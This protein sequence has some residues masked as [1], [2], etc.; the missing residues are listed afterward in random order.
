MTLFARRLRARPLLAAAGRAGRVGMRAAQLIAPLAIGEAEAEWVARAER[1]TVRQ[2]EDALKLAKPGYEP[3]PAD[4]EPAYRLTARVTEEQRKDVDEGLALAARLLPGSTREEQLEAFAQEWLGS[5][6]GD[7]SQDDK[8][9]IS[10][11][12]ERIGPRPEDPRAKLEAEPGHDALVVPIPE[13]AP[14]DVTF[15]PNDSAKETRAKLR[16]LAGLH[17]AWRDA[18]MFYAHG[19]REGR[20]YQW[21]GF[22]SF[23]HYAEDRLG[24]PHSTI[25]ALA[26]LQMQLARSPALQEAKRQKVS[27]EKLRVLARLPEEEIRSW[28]ARAQKLTV[29]ALR[30]RLERDRDVQMRGAG[31]LTAR[32]SVPVARLLLAAF[33]SVRARA[34]GL[35]PPG[36]CLAAL[37]RHFIATNKGA[38]PRLTPS[39]KLRERNDNHCAVPGCSH[40]AAHAHHLVFRSHGGEKSDEN[41]VSLCAFHHLRCIHGGHMQ[42]WG[43]APDQITWVI[44]GEVI[45]PEGEEKEK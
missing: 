29:I 34:G 27:N 2:L 11:T 24:L 39:Q 7:V 10:S 25:Q 8:R 44:G 33:E 18:A 15:D 6:P 5:D 4:P 20:V 21:L 22:A 1:E 40:L 13:V 30:R 28:I 45:E 37:A 16:E 41:L 32:V 3:E 12:F 31:K 26:S 23:R 42:A 38:A 19:L 36:S 9:R 43:K 35:I 14:V 17:A